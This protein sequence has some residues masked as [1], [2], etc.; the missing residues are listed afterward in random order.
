MTTV[1]AGLFDPSTVWVFIPVVA[2]VFGLGLGLISTLLEHQRKMAQIMSG[3]DSLND[4]IKILR[5]EV[6]ELKRILLISL[7]ADASRQA[8]LSLQ[9]NSGGIC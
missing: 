9:P 1:I 4:E 7:P 5:D 3:R 8:D 2:I 6:A